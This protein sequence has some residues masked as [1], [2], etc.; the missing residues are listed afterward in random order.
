MESLFDASGNR[1]EAVRRL[2]EGHLTGSLDRLRPGLREP[3][4]AILRHLVTSAGT[5]N[6]IL[7]SDLLER[8]GTC[9][10]IGPEIG[11]SALAELSGQSRLVRRQRRNEAYF[12]DI[13]SEFLVPWIQRQRALSDARVAMRRM[14]KRIGIAVACL[15]CG[16][17]LVAAG[18][19]Y[20]VQEKRKDDRQIAAE[21]EKDIERQKEEF[22][23]F[24][25]LEQRTKLGE[26]DVTKDAIDSIKNKEDIKKEPVVSTQTLPIGIEAPPPAPAEVSGAVDFV[27]DKLFIGHEGTVWSARYSPSGLNLALGGEPSRPFPSV[28]T[29]GQDRTAR[30]W[31]LRSDDDFVLKGHRGEVNFAMFN[32]K[33]S[34]DLTQWLAATASDDNT[35]ALWRP[36]EPTKPRFL[37]GHT[38]AVTGLAWSRDG[39]WLVTTSK[40]NQARIWNLAALD[41]PPTVLAKHTGDIWLPALVELGAKKAFLVTPS[42]DGTAR[43]WNFPAGTPCTFP[44]HE[45]KDKEVLRHGSPIRRAAM[46]SQGRWIVTAGADGRAILWDRNT[47][48]ML[49]IVT[50]QKAV[51][52]VSFKP[53][54]ALF[55][56]ASGDNTA[57]VWDAEHKLGIVTLSGHTAPLF[58]ARFTPY[59]PGVV[60][61][62]WDRTARLWNYETKT[63]VA[64]LKGHLGSL[65]SVEFSPEG[66]NFTT[67]SGDGT[68]RLWDL[69]SIPG[70]TAFLPPAK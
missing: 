39:N 11:R 9:E 28:I 55:V 59:G 22:K 2:L 44:A 66:T 46:D 6:I 14:R 4:V 70:G 48:E 26:A 7:E 69:K 20:V 33:P 43:L 68:A 45:P 42:S 61:V 64:V 62:S 17:L 47:G 12:Y 21:R 5:R 3:A 18:A 16:V 41:K 13:T 58:S 51:R 32:P 29:A 65:W 27:T 10:N 50:H 56:T 37:T 35:A 24:V 57:Q 60:T 49:L 63:C 36:S 23:S 67:T 53:G 1:A 25:A 40:D 52:D 30:V 15:L 31:D 8:L 34:S 38:A 19:I 54:S